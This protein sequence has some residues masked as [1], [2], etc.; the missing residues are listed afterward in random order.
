MS[1]KTTFYNARQTILEMFRDRGY[2]CDSANCFENVSFSDFSDEIISS[3]GSPNEVADIRGFYEKISITD[4]DGNKKD[5]EIP[6]YVHFTQVTKPKEMGGMNREPFYNNLLNNPDIFEE[7]KNRIST[8]PDQY[9][10]D[11]DGDDWMRSVM[12]EKVM[13]GV[14]ILIVYDGEIYS[15]NKDPKSYTYVYSDKNPVAYDME[16]WPAHILVRNITRHELVPKHSLLTEDEQE[17]FYTNFADYY[18]NDEQKQKLEQ[19]TTIG[20]KRRYIENYVFQLSPKISLHDPVNMYY[21][22]RL[23]QIYKIVRKGK[24]VTYR[25][26]KKSPLQSDQ[27]K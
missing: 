3:D 19:F 17:S 7:F 21:H 2:K 1:N 23:R 5:V 20:D 18:F 15:K 25:M 26:V 16:I 11:L 27:R 6:V 13:R 24:A 9:K 14:H 8:Y 22:G 12:G 10:V 4:E